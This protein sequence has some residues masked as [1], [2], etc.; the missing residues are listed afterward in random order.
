MQR[1]FI[2]F[3]FQVVERGQLAGHGGVVTGL[4]FVGVGDGGAADIKR[5]F[6]LLK[7]LGVGVFG[8]AGE[9]QRVFGQ[10]HVKIRLRGAQDQLLFGVFELIIGNQ[11]GLAALFQRGKARPVKQGLRQLQAGAGAAVAADAGRAFGLVAGVVAAGVQLRQQGR[12]A[13]D[14]F[15][16]AGFPAGARRGVGGVVFARRL[17]DV[18]QVQRLGAGAGA[19]QGEGQRVVFPCPHD[20]CLSEV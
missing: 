15:F 3:D 5:F 20:G 17:P 19:G 14:G 13:L 6:G 2:A 1:Q 9:F 18:D 11:R 8:G 4:G 16:L 7:L 12:A 10:Q